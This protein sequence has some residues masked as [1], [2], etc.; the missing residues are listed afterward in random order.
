[1]LWEIFWRNLHRRAGRK[2]LA[3]SI[4]WVSTTLM[5]ML[6][7]GAIAY[8]HRI[9][10][11]MA[12]FG[13]NFLIYAK[14]APGTSGTLE[15]GRWQSLM[16]I[17]WSNNI[18]AMVPERL[19]QGYLLEKKAWVPIAITWLNHNVS[20][21]NGR[22]LAMGWSALSGDWKVSGKWPNNVS[23]VLIGH[24]LADKLR[25]SLGEEYQLLIQGMEKTVRVRFTGVFESGTSE[26]R[27]ILLPW[28]LIKPQPDA[29]EPIHR[30]YVRVETV[31]EPL[32][33]INVDT[34]T[35]EEKERW[36]CTPYPSSIA[37]QIRE[38]L[39][40]VEVQ[41][42][43]EVLY[44]EASYL[45]SLRKVLVS[46]TG[47]VIIAMASGL[48]LIMISLVR[49]RSREIMLFLALGAS[50]PIVHGI[51][52]VESLL[53]GFTAGTLGWLTGGLF[54]WTFMKE[55]KA[56]LPWN[57][58]EIGVVVVLMASTIAVIATWFAVFHRIHRIDPQI[59]HQVG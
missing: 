43:E 15:Y 18:K 14:N 9:K 42:L 47:I 11:K 24:R 22:T 37:H 17:F 26:D 23:E 40:E 53:L 12:T 48:I 39:P 29:H 33:P 41:P 36:I 10:D 50:T 1:M 16:E 2:A 44:Q 52:L 34:L 8:E 46:L 38:A 35:P 25:I 20:L 31:P 45:R 54:T 3:W 57:Y 58:P 30:L 56:G 55:S 32:I 59:L 51:F 49:A 27:Y 21:R 7:I 28:N 4:L 6:M 5:S 19:S 13:P